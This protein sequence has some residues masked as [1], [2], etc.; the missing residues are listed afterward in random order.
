MTAASRAASA[1]PPPATELEL[2]VVTKKTKAEWLA[3]VV[4]LEKKHNTLVLAVDGAVHGYILFRRNGTEGH[5]DRIAVAES[6]RRRGLGRRLLQFAVATLRTSR[7]AMLLLEADTAN[8]GAIALYESQGFARATIRA[9]YYKPG[10]DALLME[11][12]L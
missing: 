10:R 5:I 12:K 2:V 4:R 6:Q 9:D 11:L 8:V 7:A 3:Q 1:A